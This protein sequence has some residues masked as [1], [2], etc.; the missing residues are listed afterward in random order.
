MSERGRSGAC[1]ADAFSLGQR[2]PGAVRY[3]HH[4][5]EG[6]ASSGS[7]PPAGNV[8]HGGRGCQSGIGRR[9]MSLTDSEDR[10][11]PGADERAARIDTPG[12]GL[13][14]LCDPPSRSIVGIDEFA[15]APVRKVMCRSEGCVEIAPL[16]ALHHYD[17][18]VGH[19]PG[20]YPVRAIPSENPLQFR[21]ALRFHASL[22]PELA[23]SWSDRRDR[24][25]EQ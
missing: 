2:K 17:R 3:V 25:D 10:S 14:R 22:M 16:L 7:Y 4:T 18:I 15:I 19:M 24:T 12:H 23:D 9:S 11:G 13:L 8:R 5:P 1:V 6:G 20:N 21:N